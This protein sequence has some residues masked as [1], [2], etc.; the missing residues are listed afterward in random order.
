ME[1]KLRERLKYS[2]GVIIRKGFETYEGRMDGRMYAHSSSWKS[3]HRP[4]KMSP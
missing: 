1:R 2:E 3:L 4:A